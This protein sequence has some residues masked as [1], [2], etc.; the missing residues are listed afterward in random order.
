MHNYT[1]ADGM[2]VYGATAEEFYQITPVDEQAYVRVFS[3]PKSYW[4]AIPMLEINTNALIV[5]NPGY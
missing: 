2:N 1:E 3:Y 4:L 5:Q